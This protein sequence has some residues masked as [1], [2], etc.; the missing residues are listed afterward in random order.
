MS[1][2]KFS[3]PSDLKIREDLKHENDDFIFIGNA[4]FHQ[5]LTETLYSRKIK[6]YRNNSIKRIVYKKTGTDWDFSN[7]EDVSL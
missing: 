6:S 3:V 7:I 2:I 5:N 1:I 4:R